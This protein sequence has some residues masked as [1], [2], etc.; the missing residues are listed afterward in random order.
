MP[1]CDVVLVCLKSVN[2]DKL[3]TLLPPLLHSETLVVLIQNGIGVEEDVQ[4]MFPDVQLAAGLAFICSAKTEPG[5]FYFP[6][7]NSLGVMPFMRL[8]KRAKVVT[9]AKWSW[10]EI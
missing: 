3:Q 7:L 9:S 2:N 5:V 4:K 1:P 10:S 6:F 8:K